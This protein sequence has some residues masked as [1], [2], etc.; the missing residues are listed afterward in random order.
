MLCFCAAA[1]SQNNSNLNSMAPKKRPACDAFGS[2]GNIG[3][4]AREAELARE[5]AHS[6]PTVMTFKGLNVR[7]HYAQKLME[8]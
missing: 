1:A 6:V 5:I 8:G 2:D 3:R 4:E 7:E